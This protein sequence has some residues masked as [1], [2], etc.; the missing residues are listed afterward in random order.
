[1]ADKMVCLLNLQESAPL[2]LCLLFSFR[3][4]ICLRRRSEFGE[5]CKAVGLFLPD[6]FQFS[7]FV[8]HLSR[9]VRLF[10]SIFGQVIQFPWISLRSNQFPVAYA[11]SAVAFME[12]PEEFS[13]N[14]FI[15]HDRGKQA[16]SRKRRNLLGRIYTAILF[17]AVCESGDIQN[18][19]DEINQVARCVPQLVGLRN[20]AGPMHDQRSTDTS[21]M[22][23]GLMS[24]KRS[25][26]RAGKSGT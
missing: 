9:Q 15:V 22:N 20:S 26:R 18:C 17:N 16:A 10:C 12:P 3:P 5:C 6:G 14:R 1:M 8:G 4:L 13:I 21:F 7:D 19:G 23:P 2:I 25:I 11:N 24:S